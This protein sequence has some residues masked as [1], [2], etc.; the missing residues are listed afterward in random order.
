MKGVGQGN[1][2]QKAR[3]K[4]VQFSQRKQGGGTEYRDDEGRGR[5]GGRRVK[6]QKVRCCVNAPRISRTQK[7][8][9]RRERE[10]KPG[11]TNKIRELAAVLQEGGEGGST[12]PSFTAI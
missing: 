12:V 2:N 4:T 10:G 7:N 5:R 11:V 1:V 3:E 9:E 6:S 8:Q